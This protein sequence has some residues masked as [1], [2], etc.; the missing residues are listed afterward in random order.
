[1]WVGLL[2][3]LLCQ[4]IQFHDDS[5]SA[6]GTLSPP[7]RRLV[8]QYRR[9]IVQC[10]I[11]GKY[12]RTVPYT[13]EVFFLYFQIEQVRTEGT[14]P[15]NW[16]L[17]GMLVRLAMRMG[18]H[19]DPSHSSKISPFRGEMRRRMWGAI[20]QLDLAGS[21][22]MGLPRMIQES[23]CDTAE[24]RNLLDEDFGPTCTELPPSR[25]DTFQTPILYLRE[26]KHV[27]SASRRVY[28]L[29]S[30]TKP[31]SYDDVMSLDAAINDV[32]RAI[33]SALQLKPLTIL[34]YPV[35]W[36]RQM[37]LSLL[38]AEA[39]CVLHRRYLTPG[40]TDPHY[41]YSRMTCIEA[42]LQMLDHQSTFNREK[43]RGGKLYEHRWKYN[44]LINYDFLL[45]AT[46]LSVDLD[47]DISVE[48]E[49]K[50]EAGLQSPEAE[51]RERIIKALEGSHAIWLQSCSSSKDSRLAAGVIERVLTKARGTGWSHGSQIRKSSPPFLS[52]YLCIAAYLTSFLTLSYLQMHL[53]PGRPPFHRIR[54]KP[55][56]GQQRHL[57][58]HRLSSTR[59][60]TGMLT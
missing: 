48:R 14:T 3:C 57:R 21:N 60:K 28:D 13:V 55:L 36:T 10:L 44:S 31:Y 17:L 54:A 38:L 46:L 27:L 49:G 7:S 12:T 45:A 23:Q 42:A 1:M 2:F 50:V 30:T 18:Y 52:E 35:I 24:P 15:D 51:V 11:L 32:K 25:P 9:N 8:T 29:T 26:K 33:P 59:L 4:T 39:Q 43:D 16:I 22:V 53:R 47:H 34:T 56:L 41:S 37:S 58:K 5:R 40:R 19:R 20:V 6:N